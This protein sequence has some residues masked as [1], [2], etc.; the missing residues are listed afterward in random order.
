MF[1]LGLRNTAQ[2]HNYGHYSDVQLVIGGGRPHTCLGRT[3]GA[4]QVSLI[5]FMLKKLMNL[6][7][8]ITLLT[9][10]SNIMIIVLTLEAKTKP[11]CRVS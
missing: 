1:G 5:I 7:R 2:R 4:P 6:K 11:V 9:H 8:S 10:L 3:T